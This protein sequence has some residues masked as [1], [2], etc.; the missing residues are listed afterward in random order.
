MITASPHLYRQIGR[1]RAINPE[2]IE[3]ALQQAEQVEKRGLPSVLTLGHLAHLTGASYDYLREIIERERDAYK[4]FRIR[5]RN[6]GARLIAAPEPQLA[7]VQKWIASNILNN[8]KASAASCA[9][10]P[11]SSPLK[12]ATRHVGARWL[13]KIDIHDFFESVSERSA[14]RVFRSVGYQP[15]VALELARIC[16]R[17]PHGEEAE[18]LKWHVERRRPSV[19]L[20][21]RKSTLGHLP[22]GAP[23]SPMLANLACRSLDTKLGTLSEDHGLIY[24]RYSDDIVFS[25]GSNFSPKLAGAL[26]KDAQRI[27]NAF[28]HV[29][30]GKKISVAPPGARKIVLGLLVDGDRPRLTKEYRARIGD[31]VRGIAKFGLRDHASHRH[32]ASIW[33]MVRHIEGLLSYAAM[34]E[35]SSALDDMRKQFAAALTA[36]GWSV[37][38]VRPKI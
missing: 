10:A 25:T 12:C 38:L 2:I 16:T 8:I 31:H 32:F 28:G 7:A 18:K 33:G 4:P 21:Y 19:I 26:I 15:L 36:D 22:Q 27:L 37:P 1:Q 17:L 23:S 34:V 14:Y 29:L 11:G 5:K 30:H 13:I 24:T 20:S 35:G 6:G 3:R 9:Y